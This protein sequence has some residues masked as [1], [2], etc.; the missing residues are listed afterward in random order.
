M[1][2]NTGNFA[3]LLT[4]GLR[5]VFFEWLKDQPT[6]YDKY[7][8]T[9]KSK[10]NYEEDLLVAG[11]GTMPQKFEGNPIIYQDP[12]QGNKKRYT[13]LSYGLGFRV[14]REMYDDDL[15]GPMH[16]MSKELARSGY[17]AREIVCANVLNNGGN[18]AVLG[19]NTAESLFFGLTAQ[20]GHALLRGGTFPN[21]ASTDADLGIAAL[22]AAVINFSKQ[23]DESGFPILIKP[24]MLLIPP[25]SQM[26][27]E[28]LL[29]SEYRPYT[30]TNEIN[31][32]RKYGLNYMVCNYLTDPDSW[33]LLA[34]TGE[35]DLNYFERMPLEFQSGDD[36]DTG[37]AKFKGG[38]RFSAGYGD[39]RG[40]YGSFGA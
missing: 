28:E 6:Q 10:R 11:L 25:D 3:Q 5:K 35:H 12:V 17:N 38:Q 34:A 27:A 18:T 9:N 7:L 32:I 4:P 16:R 13:H 21:R 37:D 23:V 26:I 22:E 36:F 33:F 24:R 1:A 39:W 40:T 2:A 8:N 15:Y 29:G 14:T 31:A 30:A 19:F 20:V